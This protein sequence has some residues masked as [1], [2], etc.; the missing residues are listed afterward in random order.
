MFIIGNPKEP[1][2]AA[3]FK[4]LKEYVQNGGRLLV[5]LGEGGE[6]KNNT[7][8][9]FLLEQFSISVNSDCCVRTM[10]HKYHHPKECLVNQGMVNKEFARISKGLPQRDLGGQINKN[11]FAKKY[12]DPG[13]ETVEKDDFG[14]MNFVYPYG[15]TLI[16]KKPAFT[17]LSSGPISYP[18]N[19]PLAACW[20]KGK[21]KI[22]VFGSIKMFED[23]FFE[24]EDNSKIQDG[25]FKWLLEGEADLESAVRDIPELNEY[26]RVP[27]ITA[28]A[29]R[30]RSCLQESEEI[31][32]DFT[33]MFKDEL[34]KFDTNLVPETV[35][36]FQEM[37]V[38]HEPLTLIPPQFE[39]PMPALKAAV[40]PPSLK[41]MPPPNLDLFDLDE[42]FANEK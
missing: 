17:V 2:N 19:R 38:K 14:G 22:M 27:D 16:V 32:R 36:L 23:E 7:N 3:E 12:M 15:S 25:A 30:L 18:T 10:Y 1:F 9:N 35:K 8:I 24:E 21:G 31:P 28:M 11:Q 4:Y 40:F 26:H 20:A 13:D 33:T 41:D 42:Q 37:A 6:Q 39:C 34:F 29:D 5:L